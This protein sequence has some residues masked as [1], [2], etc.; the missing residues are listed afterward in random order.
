V[1]VES[2]LRLSILRV[3][4]QKRVEANPDI[5]QVQFLLYQFARASHIIKKMEK[6]TEQLENIE[7]SIKTKEEVNLG[8]SLKYFYALG[9]S[10]FSVEDL[11]YK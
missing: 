1:E 4:L 7:W 3:S 5:F 9:E 6:F 2:I 10:R 8:Q 11:T